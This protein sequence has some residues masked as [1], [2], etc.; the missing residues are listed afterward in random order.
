MEY[1]NNHFI[2][3][4]RAYSL[5]GPQSTEDKISFLNELAERR[6]LC[7]GPWLVFGDFNLIMNASEKSNNN[8]DRNMM[9]RFR[10]FV[11]E[12]ELKDIYMHGRVYTWSNEREVPTLSRI[13]RALISME[14]DL[15]NPDSVLQALSSSALDHAP[16]HLSLNVTFRPKKRFRF[17]SFW[18]KIEGFEEAVKEAW[19]CDA[20]IIDPFKRLDALFRNSASYL[21]AWGQR[22][23]GNVKLKIAMANKVIFWLD[24]AQERRILSPEERWLRGMLKHAVLGLASFE[25]TIARQRS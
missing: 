22:R 24:V 8:L 3:A 10:N 15:Q 17:E 2:I 18:L 11:N 23:V 1:D 7:P 6:S 16:L 21:Q 19:V 4:S 20:Q 12:H 13:D 9:T 5:H 25:R 14:W